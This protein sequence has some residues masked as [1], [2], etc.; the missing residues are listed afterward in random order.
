MN[1]LNILLVVVSVAVMLCGAILLFVYGMFIKG[2]KDTYDNMRRELRNTLGFDDYQWSSTFSDM[3]DEIKRS[4]K[5]IDEVFWLPIV[6]K[7]IEAKKLEELQKAKSN[8]E[9]EIERLSK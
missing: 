3:R 9:K 5:R 6:Q 7:A 8:A 1:I 2:L 4:K